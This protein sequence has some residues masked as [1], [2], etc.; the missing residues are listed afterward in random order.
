MVV[1]QA[2]EDLD[3]ERLEC[4]IHSPRSTEL[5][6]DLAF[7]VFNFKFLVFCH[8]ANANT[9]LTSVSRSL[10]GSIGVYGKEECSVFLCPLP[11]KLL[12]VLP[13]VL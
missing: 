10:P 6:Q 8:V 9:K 12:D 5:L 11:M 13:S 4:I 1:V 2:G 7:K 3:K